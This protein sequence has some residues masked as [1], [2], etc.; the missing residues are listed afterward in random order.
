MERK[1]RPTPSKKLSIFFIAVLAVS[2][3]GI[4]WHISRADKSPFPQS[5]RAETTFPLYYP[6]PL[7]A[8]WAIVPTSFYFSQGVAGYRIKGPSGSINI[9]IQTTPRDFDFTTFYTK[10]LTNTSLISTPLG[11]GAIGKA[12]NSFLVGSLTIG[13]TWILA[14]PSANTVLQPDIQFVLNHLTKS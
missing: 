2:I 4:Y 7:P 3:S 9:T 12:D 8:E 10:K 13:S 1:R 14:A 5:V 11:E 6:K